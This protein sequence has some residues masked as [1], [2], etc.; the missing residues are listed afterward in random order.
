MEK[1]LLVV[2]DSINLTKLVAR[3][4][5]P[6]GYVTRQCNDPACALDAF[7]E[8]DPHIV[9]LDMCMPEKDGIDV[10]NE[11][12]LTDIPVKVVI[13][14]GYGAGMMRAATDIA[15]FHDNPNVATLRKP[16]RRE[17]LFA[18]LANIEA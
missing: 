8:F 6:L 17:E 14:S 3:M 1:R 12:L 18:L 13:T 9:M 10:L 2:D 4:V 16:F 15:L 7:L 5:D 11:I